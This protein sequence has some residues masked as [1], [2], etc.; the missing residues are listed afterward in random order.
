ME[1]SAPG[2]GR[3]EDERRTFCLW[4][5]G[6]SGRGRTCYLAAGRNR[7]TDCTSRGIG[8]GDVRRRRVRSSARACAPAQRTR[9]VDGD[10]RRNKD[11]PRFLGH[12]QWRD[13][14][15]VLQAQ[16]TTKRLYCTMECL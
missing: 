4:Q 15:T 13:T 10:E 2:R 11:K 5:V 1:I 12:V 6:K 14:K 9:R 16:E 7:S 3:T 8:H